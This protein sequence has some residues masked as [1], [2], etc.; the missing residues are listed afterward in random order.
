MHHKDQTLTRDFL[1]FDAITNGY[2]LMEFFQEN[3]PDSIALIGKERLI[4]DY[5]NTRPAP[6]I[7]VKVISTNWPAYCK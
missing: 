6:L 5:F 3:F 4:E 1:R 7:S 2:D